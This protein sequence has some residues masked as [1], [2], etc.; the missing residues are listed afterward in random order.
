M[1]WDAKPDDKLPHEAK[2]KKLTG[3]NIIKI[4]AKEYAR[5]TAKN[6]HENDIKVMAKLPAA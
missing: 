1:G 2:T 4:W 6:W 5:Q 3:K